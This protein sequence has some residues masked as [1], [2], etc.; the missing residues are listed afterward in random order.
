MAIAISSR[1]STLKRNWRGTEMRRSFASMEVLVLATCTWLASYFC[2]LFC[3]EEPACIQN[4]PTYRTHYELPIIL[5]VTQTSLNTSQLVQPLFSLTTCH[6]CIYRSLAQCASATWKCPNRTIARQGYFRTLRQKKQ[7]MQ[8]S[9]P[10]EHYPGR[11][12]WRNLI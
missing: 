8:S 10:N 11:R 4:R 7:M 9:Q 6:L 2:E 12:S 1:L 5:Y 3:C